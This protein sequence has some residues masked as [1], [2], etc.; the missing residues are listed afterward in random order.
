VEVVGSGKANFVAGP[1]LDVEAF[2]E[3]VPT[4]SD[5]PFTANTFCNRFRV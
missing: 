5:L 3:D 4:W 1:Q 2:G